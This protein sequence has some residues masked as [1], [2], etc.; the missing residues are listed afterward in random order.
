MGKHMQT[1]TMER[2]ADAATLDLEPAAAPVALVPAQDAPLTLSTPAQM[3]A[4]AMA[5]GDCDLDRLERLYALQQRW[6]ADQARKAFHAALAAFKAEGVTIAKDKHVFYPGKDGRPDT[7]YYHATLGN[8]VGV[9]AP[10][11]GRF[12]LSHGWQVRRENDRVFVTCTV[13]H[14]D[15]YGESITLDGP[16]DT[17]GSKNNIQAVGSSI[18]YLE[19]YTLL[20]I[21]GLATVDQDNDGADGAP[22]ERITYEQ[23]T[24]L[25]QILD[26]A[27]VAHSKLALYME[28]AKLSEIPAIGYGRALAAAEAKLREAERR[29]AGDAE[30]ADKVRKRGADHAGDAAGGAA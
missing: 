28:V 17:S 14:A 25:R 24:E 6:E 2:G 15:G 21:L 7:S 4:F 5:R 27:G 16:L 1:E 9:V 3:L 29:R 12:K 30:L 19:R 18:T 20:A 11:L 10:A 22:L 23:E 13:T 8:V 26:R